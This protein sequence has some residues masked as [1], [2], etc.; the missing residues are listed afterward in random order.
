MSTSIAL[1]AIEINR[2][3]LLALHLGR[4]NDASP[5]RAEHGAM[6]KLRGVN[7]TLDMARRAL[8][9][10]GAHGI[11]STIRFFG[12]STTSNRWS[13]MGAPPT[14]MPLDIGDPWAGLQA[15]R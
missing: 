8:H 6:G 13:P 10:L 4:L 11:R 5:L 3:T 15:V 12:I 14:W 1:R 7:V 9:V 2:A